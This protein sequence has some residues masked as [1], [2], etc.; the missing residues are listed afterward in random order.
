M[1]SGNNEPTPIVIDRGGWGDSP[2]RHARAWAGAPALKAEIWRD[3][4]AKL[5]EGARDA[6]ATLA[7]SW[8]I[9]G[10]ANCGRPN[11]DKPIVVQALSTDFTSLAQGDKDLIHAGRPI[12]GPAVIVD[13]KGDFVPLSDEKRL[14]PVGLPKAGELRDEKT[15]LGPCPGFGPAIAS[16]GQHG[17]GGGAQADGRLGSVPAQPVSRHCK[18]WPAPTA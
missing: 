2:A 12:D 5:D 11:F 14:P 1:N 16:P 8:P 17:G 4:P 6:P 15:H 7:G 18:W 13:H 9:A 10:P 3:M